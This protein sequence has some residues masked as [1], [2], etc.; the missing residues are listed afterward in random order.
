MTREEL[1]KLRKEK[2]M[3]AIYNSYGL[4]IPIVFITH[5]TDLYDYY[6]S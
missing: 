4:M 6:F 1:Y 5:L 2:D 3:K